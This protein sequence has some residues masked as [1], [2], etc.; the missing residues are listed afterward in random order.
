MSTKTAW[1]IVVVCA[2]FSVVSFIQIDSAYSDAHHLHGVWLGAGI[3]TGLIAV[4]LFFGKV[5]P[6]WGGGGGGQVK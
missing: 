4:G 6:S 5:V 1:I 2:F 3:V